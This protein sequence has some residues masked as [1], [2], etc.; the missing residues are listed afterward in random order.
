MPD[1]SAAR[2]GCIAGKINT[3]RLGAM[4]RCTRRDKMHQAKPPRKKRR[5]RAAALFSASPS[6]KSV[7]PTGLKF[8][9][10]KNYTEKRVSTKRS[11]LGLLH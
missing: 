9:K 10:K 8:F 6:L 1:E 2:V 4:A 7:G 11:P 3:M 5:L